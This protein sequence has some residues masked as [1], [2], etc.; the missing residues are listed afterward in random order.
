MQRLKQNN[1]GAALPLGENEIL[2]AST[3]QTIAGEG[4][5]HVRMRLTVDGEAER[6]VH[7]YDDQAHTFFCHDSIVVPPAVVAELST[8]V[9]AAVL[10]RESV[11]TRE[12]D[13]QALYRTLVFRD[14]DALPKALAVE[15]QH[16][17]PVGPAAAF[18]H[19]WRLF[20]GLFPSTRSGRQAIP[21]LAW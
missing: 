20:A 16:D 15:Y 1:S 4:W 7:V 11:P 8:A 5:C 18:E 9:R 3:T 13:S 12:D 19:A 17:T 2:S 14:G 21:G 6:S 10:E